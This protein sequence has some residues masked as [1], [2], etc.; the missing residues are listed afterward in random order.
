ML[1]SAVHDFLI[2]IFNLKNLFS[3]FHRSSFEK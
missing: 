3:C 2:L 1:F